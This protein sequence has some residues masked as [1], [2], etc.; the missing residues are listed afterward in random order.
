MSEKNVNNK[1]KAKFEFNESF[2][3]SVSQK[4]W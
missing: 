4:V 2:A 3:N 1:N